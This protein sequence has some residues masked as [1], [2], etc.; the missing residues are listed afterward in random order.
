MILK[1]RQY[2]SL[3]LHFIL[4][5]QV[6]IMQVELQRNLRRIED[7]CPICLKNHTESIRPQCG[8]HFYRQCFLEWF[9]TQ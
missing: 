6:L 7:E 2:Y 5:D 9:Q 4:K 8:Q 1:N 3:N